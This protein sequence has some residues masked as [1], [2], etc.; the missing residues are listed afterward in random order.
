[1]A[2]T[3]ASTVT[4]PAASQVG[5]SAGNTDAKYVPKVIAARAVG[6]ANPIVA[7]TQPDT[8]PAAG[9]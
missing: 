3:T 2:W 6:A 8:N 9:W 1:M 7:E 5:D 4:S